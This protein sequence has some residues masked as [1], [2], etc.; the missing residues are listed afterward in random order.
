MMSEAGSDVTPPEMTSRP[1]PPLQREQRRA[2][3]IVRL[4]G[5]YRPLLDACFIVRER[6]RTSP[7]NS[8][9]T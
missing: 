6:P 4:L 2:A 8:P 1:P 3:D 7:Q 5:M 9:Q